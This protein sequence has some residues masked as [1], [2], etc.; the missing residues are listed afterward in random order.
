MLRMRLLIPLVIALAV[1]G[2]VVWHV[3]QRQAKRPPD[4][5]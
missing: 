2:G 5:D 1:M 3:R 4:G